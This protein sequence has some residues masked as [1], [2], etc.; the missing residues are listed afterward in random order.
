MK[1]KVVCSAIIILILMINLTS[2]SIKNPLLSSFGDIPEYTENFEDQDID[3]LNDNINTF[4]IDSIPYI[5]NSSTTKNIMYS[6]VSYYYSLSILSEIADGETKQ[7]IIKNLQPI[8]QGSQD[9]Y[10]EKLRN[11]IVFKD[12]ENHLLLENTLTYTKNLKPLNPNITDILNK[13][14]YTDTKYVK[15]NQQQVLINSVLDFKGVWVDEMI[16]PNESFV[17]IFYLNDGTS[18]QSQYMY[19]YNSYSNATKGENYFSSSLELANGYRFYAILPNDGTSIKELLEDTNLFYDIINEN[20]NIL[21][22]VTWNI[23]KSKFTNNINL[24]DTAKEMGLNCIFDQ[25]DFSLLTEN[26]NSLYVEQINQNTSFS[27]D[28]FGV[29]AS[30]DTEIMMWMSAIEE[31]DEPIPVNMVLNKP[32]VFFITSRDN[33]IMFSGIINDPLDTGILE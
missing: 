24:L 4:G 17:D 12:E 27:I 5:L 14:Y 33:I 26:P 22:H 8:H 29:S 25:P 16:D 11:G 2:C 21:A 13:Y 30:A 7:E 23:P 1:N 6:P 3:W 15:S 28:E 18:V 10:M 9:V 20:Y 19:H 32:H 31:Q